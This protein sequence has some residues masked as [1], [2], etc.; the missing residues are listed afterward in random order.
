FISLALGSLV[1]ASNDDNNAPETSNT[2]NDSAESDGGISAEHMRIA[3]DPSKTEHRN[4][5]NDLTGMESPVATHSSDADN[6]DG[7]DSVDGVDRH[8]GHHSHGKGSN[9][10]KD[11]CDPCKKKNECCCKH[12]PTPTY[13]IS[14]CK[15]DE[16]Y[17]TIS[18][19]AQ[20][21]P[22]YYG[23]DIRHSSLPPLVNPFHTQGYCYEPC[24]QPTGGLYGS[25]PPQRLC[26]DRL[27]PCYSYYLSSSPSWLA[28]LPRQQRRRHRKTIAALTIIMRLQHH[29]SK[30]PQ[31]LPP[32]L[33]LFK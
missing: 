19:P 1:M 30:R 27:V 29:N 22:F 2:A 8:H 11:E 32:L 18:L 25:L 31:W 26:K 9:K 21:R 12:R 10:C 33:L 3:N 15:Q 16:T 6:E 23:D 28:L 13:H 20:G 17:K 4:A 14:L 7:A 24:C 5:A